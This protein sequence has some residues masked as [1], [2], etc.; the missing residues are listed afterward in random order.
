MPQQSLFGG[1]A[2]T[3]LRIHVHLN[4]GRPGGRIEVEVLDELGKRTER[5]TVTWTKD[6]DINDLSHVLRE[7]TEAWL[8]GGHGDVSNMLSSAC[9]VHLPMVPAAG[10]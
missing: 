9:K 2:I 8:W 7:V 4:P 10:E 5:Q 3:D 1:W 6:R